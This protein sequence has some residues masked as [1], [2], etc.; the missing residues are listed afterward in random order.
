MVKILSTCLITLSYTLYTS[1]IAYL[2]ITQ[3]RSAFKRS[4]STDSSNN[5]QNNSIVFSSY[6]YTN[7]TNNLD[8]IRLVDQ[9][10]QESYF[11]NVL[12]FKLQ[13]NTNRTD[14]NSLQFF[15]TENLTQFNNLPL[16]FQNFYTRSCRLEN[17]PNFLNCKPNLIL[18]F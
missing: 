2:L 8:L 13:E 18:F 10:L 12:D 15:K 3:L 14:I 7:Q 16:K 4:S 6:D 11:S 9:E 5:S 1:L 17:S